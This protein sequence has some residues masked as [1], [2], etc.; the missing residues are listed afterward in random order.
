MGDSLEIQ[1]KKL[2][3]KQS[4]KVERLHKMEMTLAQMNESL[5]LLTRVEGPLNTRPL[6]QRAKSIRTKM[7][8]FVGENICSWMDI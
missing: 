3:I 4:T 7:P 8:K 2:E 5:S 1:L 6:D